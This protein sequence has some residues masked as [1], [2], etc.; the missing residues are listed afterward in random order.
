MDQASGFPV[1]RRA[2]GK[3]ETANT[4]RPARLAPS[5][6]HLPCRLSSPAPKLLPGAV[7][8]LPERQGL[9][10]SLHANLQWQTQLTQQQ[11][12]ILEDLRAS[13][14]QL[15]PSPGRPGPPE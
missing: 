12:A 11:V 9:L 5:S 7:P 8:V 10:E 6:L 15:I 14:I 3:A 4:L 1:L 13:V 2:K